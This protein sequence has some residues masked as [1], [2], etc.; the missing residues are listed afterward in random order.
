MMRSCLLI[1]GVLALTGCKIPLSTPSH[2]TIRHANDPM[3]S[4]T[5][6]A[7][8]GNIDVTL[9][10]G[11]PH[12]AVVLRGNPQD[13]SAVQ[14]TVNHGLLR[15]TLRKSDPHHDRVHA[16]IC[17]H[18]LT[19]WVY[20]GTGTVVGSNIRSGMLDATIDN[21]GST[22]LQGQ[23][24]VRH[25]TIKGTGFTQ[26]NGVTGHGLTIN[27]AGKPRIQLAGVMDVV[28]LNMRGDGWVSLYWI[29]SQS[30]KIRAHGKGF[31]QM[32]GVVDMLDLELWD[33]ARFNGR[34]LRGDH[35]FAKTHDRAVADISVLKRQHTLALNSS[36][37]YFHNIPDM[38]ADFMA[39]AGAVLDLREWELPFMEEHTRYNR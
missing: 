10:T 33:S 37:I 27:V 22:V 4:F 11:C 3:P 14:M 19:Q 26:I 7:I 38:K 16:D 39:N 21:Q 15:L 5:R 35:V 23:I 8:N 36:N 2:H 34:Y 29:K 13:K 25:L 1:C 6:V 17:T 18:Y 24:A 31:V 30:L 32:A 12:T 9:H 28:A 20:R